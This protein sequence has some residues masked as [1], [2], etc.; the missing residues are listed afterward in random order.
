MHKRL[1]TAHTLIFTVDEGHNQSTEISPSCPL[2]TD[3]GTDTHIPPSNESS[4]HINSAMF[5]TAHQTSSDVVHHWP[6]PAHTHLHQTEPRTRGDF[7]QYSCDLTLDSNT[8]NSF[9]RLSGDR[10]E[11]TTDH[12]P[13]PY[14]DHPERFISWTQVLCKEAL[15]GRAYW[16][17]EWRD[18][19]GVSIGVS[20][21]TGGNMDQKLGCNSKSWSLDFSDSLCLFQHNKFSVEIHTPMPHRVGVYLDHRAGTLAFYCI[22]LADDTMILLHREQTTFTQPL[23]PGFWVR[24]GSTLKLCQTF[25]FSA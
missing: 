22:S 23:Y 8:A 4:D 18:G 3:T 21:R 9:L 2:N 15:S 20:Y 5:T 10:T 12:E 1:L 24:L 25:S 11:V 13:Q 17:V 16:E 19:G 14:P 6:L 7:L